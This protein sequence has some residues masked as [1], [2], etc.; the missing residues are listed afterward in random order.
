VATHIERLLAE[1]V[2]REKEMSQFCDML[3]DTGTCVF[4]VWGGGGVG[5]SS[6]L[7]KMIHEVASRKIQ[8]SE[9]TWTE[10]R[11]HDY[12]AIMRKMRDD[13]GP[14]HFVRF[15]DLVNFFTVPQYQLRVKIEGGQISVAEGARIE[16]GAQVGDIA[17]IIIKDATL[18][19]PRADM[20]V[21]PSERRARLTDAFVEGVAAALQHKSAVVFFD[22]AEKMTEETEDWVWKELLPA[23]CDFRL[24]RVKLVLCGRRKPTVDRL[25]QNVIDVAELQPLTAEHI[26]AYLERRGVDAAERKALADMLLVVT[27]GNMLE[28]ATHVDGYL[29]LQNRKHRESAE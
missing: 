11:N 23:A 14:E 10:T 12:L 21:S 9:I 22:A 7:A 1:F 24:G 26:L 19:E 17:G 28:L 16:A 3:D 20:Q 25:W 5:K 2:N 18:T 27:G 29:R 4:A 6:L 13:L 15:T 8:K